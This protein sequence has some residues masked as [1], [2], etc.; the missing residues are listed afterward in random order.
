MSPSSLFRVL[1]DA[2]L[3]DPWT[4]RLYRDVRYVLGNVAAAPVERAKHL[5]FCIDG[6][7][8]DYLLPIRFGGAMFMDVCTWALIVAM[9]PKSAARIL[10]EWRIRKS[11]RDCVIF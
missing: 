5:N 8:R 6:T 1:R 10:Y 2:S 9:T 11:F 7:V 4:S 3:R